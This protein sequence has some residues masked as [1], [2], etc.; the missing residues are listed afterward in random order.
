MV[1]FDC[2]CLSATVIDCRALAKEIKDEVKLE[3]EKVV[4][5]GEPPPHLTV[6][7]VGDDP[8]STVYIKNKISAAKYTGMISLM[9]SQKN[10]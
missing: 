4:A 10:I 5:A 6:I 7:Q 3:V 8:A 2:R 1:L 9:L